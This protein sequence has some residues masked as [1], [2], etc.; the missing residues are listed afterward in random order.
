MDYRYLIGYL[1][2]FSSLV[3]FIL[4]QRL[5]HRE[6]QALLLI[7]FH[8]PKIVIAIFSLILLPG[9][10]IHELSHLFTAILLRV[11]VKRLSLIP[12]TLK[13]GQLRLGYV[14][15]QKC[16]VIRDSIVGAAPFFAGL[17][18]L[19][20]IGIYPLEMKN[21][22]SIPAV[23]GIS[24]ILKIISAIFH[25]PD[26]L[27]WIYLAFAISSTMLPSA[28]DRIS[29]KPILFGVIIIL[30]LLVLLGYGNWIMDN[31]VKNLENKFQIIAIVLSGSIITHLLILIPTRLLWLAISH[32]TG[33]RLVRIS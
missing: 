8:K 15:T 14:E 1:F 24:F 32:I 20:Y 21:L 19:A 29:W 6:I 9:V 11:P 16:D 13:N 33:T 27:I 25:Q 3:V 30:I 4:V 5:L 22:L 2:F 31:I 17:M 28:S 7:I 10:F 18:V 23:G 26:F 12:E